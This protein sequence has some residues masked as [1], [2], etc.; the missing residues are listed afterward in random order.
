MITLHPYISEVD[1]FH[2]LPP[3][4]RWIFNK[5]EL[6]QRLSNVSCGPVGT[7]MPPGDYCL[8]PLINIGGMAGGGFRKVTIDTPRGI[9]HEPHGYCWT[10][11]T[12]DFRSWRL[13]IDDDCIHT[14]RTVRIEDDIEYMVPDG[15]PMGLPD[16]LKNISRYLI[17]E[18]LGDVIIDV[19][20]R[21]MVEE[22][23]PDVIDDYRER[24]DPD[25]EPPSYGKYGFQTQM[26]RVT[27]GEWTH[28]VEIE[29]D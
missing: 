22:M 8:R 1:A 15:E 24:V 29:N 14:Q 5:L 13:Y 4:N 6:C 27:D 16:Q 12:D 18:T 19:G 21:H 26:G 17:V 7:W 11:W 23:D 2:S 10:P 3:E 25:Y 28:L 20:P 9:V